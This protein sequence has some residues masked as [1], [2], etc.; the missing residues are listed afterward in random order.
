[1]RAVWPSIRCGPA[2]LA[3]VPNESLSTPQGTLQ[4]TQHG[5]RSRVRMAPGGGPDDATSTIARDGQSHGHQRYEGRSRLG[6]SRE[7]GLGSPH[8]ASRPGGVSR[9]PASTPLPH[10]PRRLL[11]EPRRLWSGAA[12]WLHGC[13]GRPGQS[14]FDPWCIDLD[15]LSLQPVM[16]GLSASGPGCPVR[17]GTP[18]MSHG[19]RRH[20]RSGLPPSH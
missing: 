12:H 4:G 11:P 6:G 18:A 8:G 3:D 10:E 15:G 13:I 7:H 17:R 9:V 1:M 14:Y 5:R 16:A 19:A 2:G 20:D